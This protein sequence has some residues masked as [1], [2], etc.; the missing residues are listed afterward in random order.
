MNEENTT[1][2]GD[3]HFIVH[4]CMCRSP[5]TRLPRLPIYFSG[6]LFET[7]AKSRLPINYNIL[8]YIGNTLGSNNNYR[9]PI[10]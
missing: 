9:L 6:Y 2:A 5:V 7:L 3:Q 10:E 1:H 8:P 4:V